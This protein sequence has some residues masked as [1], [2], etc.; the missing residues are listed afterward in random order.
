MKSV[1]S[2]DELHEEKKP[3]KTLK[4]TFLILK[5]VLIQQLVKMRN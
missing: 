2:I 3:K 5:K 4:E 1:M